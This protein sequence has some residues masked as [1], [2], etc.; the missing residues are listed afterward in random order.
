MRL[1]LKALLLSA[2][3]GTRLRPLTLK[4]PKCLIEIN[5]KPILG[6]W[7]DE[8]KRVDCSEVLVNT[9]YLSDKVIS[10]LNSLKEIN[11]PIK[12][13]YE[14]E[15]LGTAK[16]IIENKY[17]FKDSIGLA[18]HA[19]NL[20]DF[21]LDKL[22]QSHKKRTK[23]TILTMLTFKTDYPER[24]GIVEVDRNGVLLNFH[25]KVINP[26][27]KI[28]NGAIYVFDESFINYLCKMKPTPTD[29]SKDVIPK[30]ISKVQTC[31]TEKDLIDIG[32]I[33]SLEK[34]RYIWRK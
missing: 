33:D 3:M 31:Y 24:S 16:T 14:R 9:H 30:L 13:T 21:D 8:L 28:A 10:Y 5:G 1:K 18:I 2:G 20:T 6:K 29:I 32:T 11:I 22:I 12:Y 17:F 27:G 15:L 4:T 7:I 26:P 23:G 19:D 25:E 34:A